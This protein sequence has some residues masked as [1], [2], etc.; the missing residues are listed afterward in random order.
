VYRN[1]VP[2]AALEGEMLRTLADAE[3]PVAAAAAAA[4]A[5]RPVPV[6]SG[7]VGRPG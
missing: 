3:P 2:L 1:G 5:G 4:A 6:L 7:V